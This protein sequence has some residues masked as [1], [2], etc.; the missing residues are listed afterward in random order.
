MI[1]K[2]SLIKE[3]QTTGT[4]PEILF[5]ER[6]IEWIKEKGIVGIVIARGAL[7]NRESALMR[8]YILRNTKILAIVNCHENTFE[9]YNGSKA[10]FLIL[11]KKTIEEMTQIENP[12]KIFMAVSKK[13]GQNSRG[14]AILKKNENAKEI[15]VNGQPVLD[16]D[17]DEI[18]QSYRSWSKGEGTTYDFS[19]EI[20]SSEIDRPY[21]N[22]N[23]VKYI[24]L[25]NE[26]IKKVV[27]LGESEDWEIHR[28][29]DIAKVFNGPRF[30]RPY[31]D[32]GVTSGD[33]I[34]KYYTGTASTQNKGENI[35]YLDFNKA[36]NAQKKQLQQ[37]KIY[38]DWILITDSGTLGRII[39]ARKE[40]DGVVATNNLI[41]VV[42]D[43]EILRSYVYQFLISELGQNQMLRHAY[44]TNQDHIEPWHV[45]DVLIPFSKDENIWKNIG[46]TALEA[47]DK[48]EES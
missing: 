48:L 40:H 22:L 39:R 20:S 17:M 5:L 46:K 2:D 47:Q 37:L 19:F 29:G 31:A 14:E 23:P 44:G 27:E 33:G 21:L 30:K 34:L 3:C 38:K 25:L 4:P 32:D 15:L 45:Q 13:I 1:L 18:L 7:D 35:K 8:N 36:N 24:P 9:P 12:Y 16:H 28:L 10:A 6:C 26:S 11:Q 41:R 42:I 43:D